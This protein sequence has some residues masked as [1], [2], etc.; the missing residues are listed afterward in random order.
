MS[1]I[2]I[3]ERISNTVGEDLKRRS[4]RSSVNISFHIKLSY[5]IDLWCKELAISDKEII[6]YIFQGCQLNPVKD[7]TEIVWQESIQENQ[8]LRISIPSCKDE[9][10]LI[11]NKFY[12][13]INTFLNRMN[14]RSDNMTIIAIMA[15][16]VT[17]IGYWLYKISSQKQPQQTK[18]TTFRQEPKQSGYASNYPSHIVQINTKQL[19]VLV[20]SASQVDFLESL[21]A[22]KCISFNDGTILYK[23]TKYLWIGSESALNLKKDNLNDYL[24][25]TGEESEY[26]INLVYLELKQSDEGF[27]PNINQL[28]RYDAFRKLSD[29]VVNFS[30]SPR[31][32]MEAYENFKVYSR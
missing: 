19:L 10:F 4:A 29:L 23:I 25:A 28:E 7:F 14:I 3:V 18:Q 20:V 5:C 9:I 30:I 22:E 6:S 24:V 21:K 26:D 8:R 12:Q 11:P 31:L 1:F 27:N 32:Q 13:C 16:C 15:F 2:E 17:A